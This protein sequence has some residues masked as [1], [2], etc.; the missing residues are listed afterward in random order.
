MK[1][2]T[3]PT[4]SEAGSYLSNYSFRSGRLPRPATSSC[5][6]A[7]NKVS[8]YLRRLIKF[9]QVRNNKKFLSVY[10]LPKLNQQL[11]TTK[12]SEFLKIYDLIL[13]RLRI[14][15]LANAILVRVPTESFQELWIQKR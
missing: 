13:A 5:S 6:S 2:P 3:S 11:S 8:K 15:P 9:N 12:Y 4:P 7:T 1:Q 10:S 14:C